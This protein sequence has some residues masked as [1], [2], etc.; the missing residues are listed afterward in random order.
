MEID[1]SPG[2]HKMTLVDEN[3]ESISWNFEVIK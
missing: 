2:K 3:G 1:P